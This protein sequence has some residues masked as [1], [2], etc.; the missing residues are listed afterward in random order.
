[1]R[2]LLASR[3]IHVA[4][5]LTATSVVAFSVASVASAQVGGAAQPGL[6]LNGV[7]DVYHTAA[8][9]W[10][11]QLIPIAQRTFMLLAAFEFCIS[12]IVWAIKRESLDDLAAKFL[13][14]FTLTAF[15]LALI[16]S[17]NT[18]LLPIFNGFAAAG[19][20]AIGGGAL[21]PN[22]I[23]EQGAQIAFSLG[24]A[25]MRTPLVINAMF[26]VVGALCMIVTFASY[27]AIAIQVVLVTVDCYI[28]V[29]GGGVLFLGFAASRWTAAYAEH[30]IAHVFYLGAQT[31]LL[32]LVVAAGLQITG[33]IEPYIG[34]GQVIVAD[35]GLLFRIVGEVVTFAV[36]ACTIPRGVATR[37]M[38]HSSFGLAQALRALS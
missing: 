2:S 38:T 19:Q 13:L 7:M 16:T 3:P 14:K 11:Q 5:M 36:V 26:A 8:M 27:L 30:L 29:L 31:F 17:V 32:Y 25:M 34:Q 28:T 20:Q 10:Q 23:V 18:W 12:G 4:A 35:F 15:L 37:L 21:S 33:Q 24:L 9:G 6:G 22:W 1:M